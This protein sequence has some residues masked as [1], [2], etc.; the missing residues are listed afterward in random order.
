[1]LRVAEQHPPE[2]RDG[3]RGPPGL[4]EGEGHRGQHRGEGPGLQGQEGLTGLDDEL[5]VAGGSGLDHHVEPG[6][7]V[8]GVRRRLVLG[9]PQVAVLLLLLSG[10][11]Y[12][13]EVVDDRFQGSHRELP[14]QKVGGQQL[15]D[16]PLE[17]EVREPPAQADRGKIGVVAVFRALL[18]RRVIGADDLVQ[19]DA[20]SIQ[21][22][23]PEGEEVAGGT[24]L[25]ADVSDAGVVQRV[26][27][28]VPVEDQHPVASAP[29]QALVAGRGEVIDPLEGADLGA[30]GL[31]DAHG[32]VRGAG[33]HDDHLIHE[34]LDR[35]QAA[36][37]VGGLVLDDHGQ[38]EGGHGADHT[39]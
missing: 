23:A 8:L 16:A 22:V 19:H 30:E 33:V 14:L 37:Q 34:A 20:A 11:I 26:H 1:M 27:G 36:R 31:G 15:V 17:A 24:L 2:E 9:H 12:L 39:V 29:A 7:A 28:L 5:P 25:C 21:E 32:V 35:P 18:V 4:L 38:G 6:L 3:L 10:N 13:P